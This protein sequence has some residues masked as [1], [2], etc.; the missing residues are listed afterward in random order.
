[1]IESFGGIHF[2]VSAFSAL[3]GPEDTVHPVFPVGADA[4]DAFR[5]EIASLPRVDACRCRRVDAPNTRVRLFHDASASYNTQLVRS[6]DSIPFG[7]VEPLLPEVDLVYINFMTGV[8]LTLADAER[9]RDTAKG[10]VYLDAHMIAYRVGE[11]GHRSTAPVDDWRR[12]VDIPDVLQCNERELAALAPDAADEA[13]AAA[14]LFSVARL[15]TLVITKG[16]D[17]A[18]VY[19]RDAAPLRIDVVSAPRVL[20]TTGCGDVFGSTFAWCLASGLPLAEAGAAASRAGAF[21]AGIP[22]SHGMEGLAQA[23][24]G[25][26]A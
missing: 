11:G 7:D 8:D 3:A 22:G 9:L 16:E 20:D 17:G 23:V 25:V 10:L 6:L 12:W 18:R 14:M 2:P 24:N 4:W 19:T 5:R 21:V 13:A 15:R 26:P 1:V